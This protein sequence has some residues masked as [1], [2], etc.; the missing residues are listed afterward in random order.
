MIFEYIEVFYS[1]VRLRWSKGY[2]PPT[3]YRE[4]LL[5]RT[6]LMKDPIHARKTT[7]RGWPW[8][9]LVRQGD[10]CAYEPERTT[11]EKKA[12][13]LNQG[14]VTLHMAARELEN[15]YYDHV[16]AHVLVAVQR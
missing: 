13:V 8:L 1:G 10:I 5:E 9:R 2:V 15:D 12:C 4:D 16:P 11:D 6:V 14:K 3:E 7:P